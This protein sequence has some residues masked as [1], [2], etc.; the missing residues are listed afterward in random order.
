MPIK[1]LSGGATIILDEEDF[2]LVE[3]NSWH[4][5]RIRPSMKPA[6]AR[7]Q[8]RYGRMFRL[9][10][11]REIAARVNPSLVKQKFRVYPHNG[12]YLDCRR[13]NLEIAVGKRRPGRPRIEPRPAGWERHPFKGM[14]WT[15]LPAS[16]LW[17]GGVVLKDVDQSKHG[18]GR[19][20]RRFA[21]GVEID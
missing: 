16:Q 3:A 5:Y 11:H 21:G 7:I 9:H 17:A 8:K 2:E 14:V 13:E 20:L 18:R 12:D 4:V 1:V 6:V 19:H 10:L 15:Q